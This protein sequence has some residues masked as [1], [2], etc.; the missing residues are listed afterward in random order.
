MKAQAF[1]QSLAAGPQYG[2]F[3]SIA[4]YH[5]VEAVAGSGFGFLIIDGEHTPVDIPLIHTQLMAVAPTRTAAIVRVP[6]NDI[7]AIKQCL[8][9][10]ADGIMVP[11]VDTAEQARAAVRYT[12]YPPGGVRGMAGMTRASNYSRN[13][14]YAA[15]AQDHFCLVL[16]IESP[17][18]LKN[19]EEICAVD[20]VD[21]LF[22]GPSDYSAN[23][24]RLGQPTHPDVQNELEEGIRR[25]RRAGKAAGILC[26]EADAP[27]FVAAGAT[28]VAVGLDL[29]ILVSGA[30][31]L[32]NRLN[33]RG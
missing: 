23:S 28:L 26:S 27:R 7:V 4:S 8:D 33:K 19:L 10:G 12:R 15:N 14:A 25:V 16:Q 3:C 31:G 18:G 22:F 29:G 24:D 9:L 30:D 1:K 32:A 20:G 17:L 11:M 2:L 5:S 13:K 6:S 21:A